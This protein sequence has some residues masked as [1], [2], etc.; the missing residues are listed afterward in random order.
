MRATHATLASTGIGKRVR[1]ASV[2]LDVDAAA[3]LGAVGLHDGEE[4]VVLRRAAFGGPLH[5]RTASGGEFAVG[6]EVAMAI[7]VDDV[8]NG[9]TS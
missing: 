4:L 5:V 3:W 2:T 6:R 9:S 7:G 1:I 8:Q